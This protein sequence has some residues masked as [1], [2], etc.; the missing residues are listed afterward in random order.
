MTLLFAESEDELKRVVAEFYSVCTRR[1][2]KSECLE[3][4][5]D[6]F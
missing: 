2:Q 3:M 5:G 6:G 1:K 4:Y